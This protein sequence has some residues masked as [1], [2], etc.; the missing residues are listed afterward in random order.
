MPT[1]TSASPDPR[2]SDRPPRCTM[3]RDLD[4]C[5]EPEKLS[6]G[7]QE[8]TAG[9]RARHPCRATARSGVASRVVELAKATHSSVFE[10]EQP[11][12]P[13][14]G[15][16]DLSQGNCTRPYAFPSVD[17]PLGRR[18]HRRH[19]RWIVQKFGGKSAENSG[20]GSEICRE[21]GP[22]GEP[23]TSAADPRRVLPGSAKLKR[24]YAARREP[25][26]VVDGPVQY[27][28][29]P[30]TRRNERAS[31]QPVLVH[32]PSGDINHTR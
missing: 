6:R 24:P 18:R 12:G 9:I 32:H 13:R 29:A 1:W 31:P 10:G 5:A 4:K 2:G 11:G 17:D 7:G 21:H 20:K 16:P 25:T 3:R 26:P 28:P 19:A 15:Q 22:D 14:H 8:G 23:N 30:L 27:L